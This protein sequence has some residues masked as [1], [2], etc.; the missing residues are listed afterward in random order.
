MCDRSCIAF[1]ERSLLPA[2]VAG[3]DVLE[4]GA[5]DVNGSLRPWVESLHPARYIGVDL[6]PGPGVDEVVDAVDLVRRFGRESFDLVITTEMVEHTRDWRTVVSNLKGVLRP[7]AHL[8]LTTRSPG[9]PYHAWPYDFWRYEPDDMRQIFADLEIVTVE[10][11]PGAAGVFV[12]ARRPEVFVERTP[13][14]ALVSILSG[15]RQVEVSPGQLRFMVRYRV[16]PAISR[17]LAS[18]SAL[19]L[20]TRAAQGVRGWRKAAWRRLPVAVRS[21]VKRA[22]GRA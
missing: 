9:F 12:L 2:M 17:R 10:P 13:D 5:L 3:R 19:G 16:R 18:L 7:G 11:D 1:G 15:R 8:L 4:V 22:F 14:L 21:T 20:G 6:T